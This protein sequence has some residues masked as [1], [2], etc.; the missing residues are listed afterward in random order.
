MRV[1]H[2]SAFTGHPISEFDSRAFT[3]A[4]VATGGEIHLVT[5]RL[6]PGGVIGRHMAVGRQ[7]LMVLQGEA[8]VSGGDGGSAVLKPGQA[9]LWEPDESHETRTSQGVL[10][11]IVEG[12][13]VIDPEALA[14][15]PTD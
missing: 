7:I 2:L 11:L 4:P 14:P 9:A 10:A 8:V 15:S 3:V 6:G 12:D 13:L 5:A 1:L